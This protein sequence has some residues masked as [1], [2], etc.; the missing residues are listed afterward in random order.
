MSVPSNELV[1]GDLIRLRTGDFVQADVRVVEGSLEVVQS[2]LT[3][4][5]LP[6]LKGLNDVLFSGS[7]IGRGEATGL[8]TSTGAQTYFGRT[9]Q[10]VQTAGPRLHMEEITSEVVKWLLIMAGVFLLVGLSVSVVRGI[11]LPD[12]LPLIVVLLL[13]AVPVALPTMFTLTM[14][15]GSMELG[16]NGVLVTR[17]SAGE[18]AA[19]MDILCLDKTGTITMNKLFIKDLFAVNGRTKEEIVL[20]GALASQE[21]NQDPIDLAFISSAKDMRVPLEGYLQKNFI[22][23]DP[24][25]RRTEAELE[26]DGKKII[27]IKGAIRTIIPLCRNSSSE[28]SEVEE[29]VR[30]LFSKGYRVLAVAAGSSEEDLRLVGIAALYDELWPDSRMLISELKSLGVSVKMLP[31]DAL[32]IAKEIAGEIGLDGRATRMSDLKAETDEA[33]KQRISEESEVFAEVYP[34]DKYRIVENLQSKKHV[35]GM[36]GDG[37]NDAPALRQAEVGIAVSNA[38]DVAKKASSVVLTTEGLEGIIELIK[39]GR[40]IYQRIITWILN[41]VIKTFQVV[42]FVILAFLLTGD[43]IISLFSMVLLLLLTDF[44]TL[45]ISTDNVRY[46]TKPDNWDIMNLVEVAIALGILY[47]IE[48]TLLLYLG[49]FHLGLNSLEQLQTFIFDFLVFSGLFNVIIV[50]ERNHFWASRP[51]RFLVLSILGD[52]IIVLILSIFGVYSLAP[53]SSL[54]IFGALA[55]SLIICFLINDFIKVILVRRLRVRM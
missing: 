13:S 51:S 40:R 1:P 17:L 47:V 49:R 52:I 31:G 42:V 3:G 10:L 45:S 32:Q 46:S 43:Y 33:K 35:V 14:A 4:E 36:T 48:S 6:I 37:V 28:I 53:I 34:E 44:V 55:Y 25:N 27:A 30:G 9:I 21:A 38:T 50:R 16:K 15:L 11:H 20:F 39:E 19:T 54:A 26:K 18:D 29:S 24:T 2:A 41:K 7:V 22:P 5:S 12:F 23:F 8:V